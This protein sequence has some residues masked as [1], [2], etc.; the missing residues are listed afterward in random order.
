VLHCRGLFRLNGNML[1]LPLQA[2]QRPLISCHECGHLNRVANLQPGTRLLCSR[3]DHRLLNSRR[4]WNEKIIALTLTGTILFLISNL[5]PFIGLEVA[6][7][8]QSSRL[9]SGVLALWGRDQWLLSALVFVTIFLFPLMELIGFGLI[10]ACYRGNKGRGLVR[11]L[12]RWLVFARPWNMLEIFLIGVLVTSFKLGNMAALIPGAGIYAYSAL[13]LVLI[14]ANQQLQAWSIWQWVEPNNCFLSRSPPSAFAVTGLA[15]GPEMH[16]P[17]EDQQRLYPCHACD[18]LVDE[19]QVDG[20]RPCPRCGTRVHRRIPHSLQRTLALLVASAI[21]YIPANTM[22]IMTTTT[23]GVSESS[24]ILSGVQHLAHSGSWLL[25]TVVF[26]ASVLV[27]VTKMLVIGF[28]LWSVNRGWS[29][30][31]QQ[32]LIL[33]RI[34]EQIGR[35]SMVDVYV[36][37]LL[38]VLVQFG[39]LTAVEPGAATLAFA[40]VV[41]LT[42]LAAENFDP[43]LIWDTSLDVTSETEA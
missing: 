43:R 17:A 5:S 39:L 28:L 1:A 42:M 3:C 20:H 37:T 41:V 25:A 6:G 31:R 32:R 27:P 36:V 16:N 22:P 12:L 23:L 10:M 8:T 11:N 9:L 33:Y 26:V 40:S 4:N 29:R 7:I 19:A 14:L 30:D 2:C 13:V 24:T 38:V 18:A 21:L 34:T 35:W 15:P